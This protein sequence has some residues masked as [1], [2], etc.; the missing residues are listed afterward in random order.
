MPA[1]VKRTHAVAVFTLA[2][3]VLAASCTGDGDDDGNTGATGATAGATGAT[4]G[5]GPTPVQS[6]SDTAGTYEYSNA[7]LVAVLELD[8]AAGSLEVD[9]GTDHEL[10]DPGF[11]A[12]H[13]L[14]GARTDGVVTD[15]APIPPGETGTFEIELEGLTVGDIGVLGLLFG[16]E[17][18][19]L[20]V[21]TA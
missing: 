8:G 14:T 4:G 16:E 19:G 20:L 1:P 15:P 12:R 6:G 3:A 7:G 9:N 21:R 13:A 17:D 11:Y 5:E 2:L 10:P 18:Y